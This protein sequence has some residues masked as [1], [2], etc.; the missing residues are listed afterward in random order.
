[1]RSRR[2]GLLEGQA[3][4]VTGGS[5]GLGYGIVTAFVREGADLALID[6]SLNDVTDE[7]ASELKHWGSQVI[8]LEADISDEIQVRE[9]SHRVL[10]AFGRVDVL[11]NNAAVFASR[12]LA[13]MPV[14]E[15]DRV[16]AVNLRGTF[17]CTRYLLPSMLARGYGRII[18]IASQLGQVGEANAVPYST[19]KGGVIAFTRA[20]AREVA[21]HGVLVN[22]VAPGPILTPG[23]EARS[24]DWKREKLRTLPIG[25]FA[26]V[27][28]IV[29]AVLLLASASGSY[30]VGQ[31]L[32]P[33]GGDVMF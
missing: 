28:E 10:S 19:S 16:I 25:R 33:N 21:P 27:E 1:M 22:A 17:L 18:N 23:L 4:V 14:S 13:T 2:P 5:R 3:A 26:R 11:V 30:F 31:T 6:V 32:G 8:L 24:S 12:P 29:P 20:L 15:W 7:I 9:M